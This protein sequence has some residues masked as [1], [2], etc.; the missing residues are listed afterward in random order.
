MEKEWIGIRKMGGTGRNG[1]KGNYNQD[2]ITYIKNKNKK[3]LK[4]KKEEWY[5]LLN[6][7]PSI[8]LTPKF[9]M[10]IFLNLSLL[11]PRPLLL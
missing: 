4:I 8:C 10:F 7:E 1:G 9:T 2:V 11:L 6:N 5:V 3:W